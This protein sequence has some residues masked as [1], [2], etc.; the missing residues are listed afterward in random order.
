MKRISGCATVAA[1]AGMLA[2]AP[3]LALR[4]QPFV[5]MEGYQELQIAPAVYFVA[6][7]ATLSSPA[8]EIEVAWRARSA[9]LCTSQGASHFIALA[10]SFEPVLKTDL[11]RTGL[12]PALPGARAMRAGNVVYIPIFTPRRNANAAIDAPTKQGHIR[13]IKDPSAAIKP[14]RLVDG[15]KVIENAKARGWITVAK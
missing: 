15:I 12:A 13:C 4:Y 14:E 10:F 7:H 9:E 11:E 1:L 3:A 2:A 6:F 5:G 8:D